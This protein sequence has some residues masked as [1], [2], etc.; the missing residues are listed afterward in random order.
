VRPG[1]TGLAQVS[2]RNALSWDEKFALDVAYV[3]NRSLRLDLKI[4]FK[5]I[6]PVLTSRGISSGDNAT[7]TEF[8]GNDDD[9]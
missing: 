4:L 2:G 9:A 8:K 6:A 7:M 5:T 1:I 3:D